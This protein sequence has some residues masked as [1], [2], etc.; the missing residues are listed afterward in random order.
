MVFAV[1]GRG[2]SSVI[3]GFVQ[4]EQRQQ[5]GIHITAPPDDSYPSAGRTFSPLR[6][7]LYLDYKHY[8]PGMN[9]TF[10]AAELPRVF[11]RSSPHDQ[12]HPATKEIRP[13]PP[14][15]YH[16]RRYRFFPLFLI[17]TVSSSG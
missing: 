1:V 12:P 13:P 2:C 16:P 17:K 9:L 11:A 7:E 5:H 4:R 10:M 8:R 6:Q 15:A 14:I 3:L